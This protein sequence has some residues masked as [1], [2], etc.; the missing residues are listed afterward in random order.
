MLKE[1]ARL[2]LIR[3]LDLLIKGGPPNPITPMLSSLGPRLVDSYIDQ[4]DES[5]I[6]NTLRA[7]VDTC[8]AVLSSASGED[9]Q[10]RP[11]RHDRNREIDVSTAANPLLSGPALSDCGRKT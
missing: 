9:E 2:A 10:R 5:E 11:D 3:L 6:V 4:T 7:I 8:N 1:R